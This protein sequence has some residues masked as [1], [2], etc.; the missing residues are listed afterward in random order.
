MKKLT[1]NEKANGEKANGEKA[2]RHRL[3]TTK[4]TRSLLRNCQTA[5]FQSVVRSGILMTFRKRNARSFLKT[6]TMRLIPMRR[7]K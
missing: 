1:I 2:R 5:A 3:F 6:G 4:P 7:N